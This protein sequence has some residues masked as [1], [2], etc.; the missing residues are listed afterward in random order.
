MRLSLALL[1]G[2][3]AYAMMAPALAAPAKII[4][5]RHGE[6]HN[7]WELCSTG[8]ARAVALVSTYLGKGAANSLFAGGEGLA[9]VFAI[10]PHTLELVAP[11]AATWALPVTMFPVLPAKH[12][13]KAAEDA[14]LNLQTRTAAAS[15]LDDPRWT[16]KTVVM[17]WEHRHIANAD[18]EQRFAPE[19]VTLRQLL[20]LAGLPAVPAT[21]P[22][23]NYDY[24]WIVEYAAG[25][26]KPASF[27]MQKQVF[28]TAAGVPAN[29][30]GTPQELPAD[31]EG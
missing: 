18:L 19:Q 5:L 27:R 23:A 11:A 31:C 2:A 28:P 16:G 8:Q 3:I 1:T 4:V 24:F 12:Q 7:P 13:S 9:A 29:D 22:G 26:S 10:T 6:K 21:W 25:S 20:G 15:V 17:S 30:W 14:E